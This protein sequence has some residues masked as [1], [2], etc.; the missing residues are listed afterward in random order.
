MLNIIYLSN[1]LSIYT[2]L[3]HITYTIQGDNN[4]NVFP[5][6]LAPSMVSIDMPINYTKA[7]QG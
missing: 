3:Y 2:T 6:A 7:R 4:V 5:K 1:F